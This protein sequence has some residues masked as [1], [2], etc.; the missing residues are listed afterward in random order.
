MAK[1][2]IF[3]GGVGGLT[4]AHEAIE[5]GFEVEIYDVKPALWGGKARSMGAPG[6]GVDGRFDLPGEHGFRFFPGFYKH[7]PDTMSRIPYPGNANG[8]LDNL[9]PTSQFALYR[10]DGPPFIAPVNFPD[11]LDEWK[12]AMHSIFGAHLGV[13]LDNV[14]FFAGQLLKL[15]CSCRERLDEEYDLIPWWE[16][17]EAE[18]RGVPYQKFVAQ[19][20]TRSLVAMQAKVSSTRT[21]GTM[22]LQLLYNMLTPG[23]QVDRVLN[24]PTND[25]WIRP[26]TD[27]LQAKG[28]RMQLGATLEGFRMSGS[29][30]ASAT[31]SVDGAKREIV[32]DYY[33]SAIPA[34]KM[35]TLL[36]PEMLAAD[37]KLAT[38]RQLKVEWMNGIQ[39]Y[40]GADV[41]VIRGHTIYADS[42]WALTSI[43]QHQFWNGVDLSRYGNG[44]V[45]GILSIDVSDWKTSGDKVVFKPAEE[46]TAEEIKNECWAQ[47]KAHLDEGGQ[48]QLEDSNLLG[49]HLDPD[50][51]FGRMHET[52][53]ENVEPLLI[54]VVGSL[55]LRPEAVTGIRNLFLASDYANNFTQ[56]AT[57]EGANEN[58]RRAVNGILDAAGSDA[59][60]CA[61]WPYESPAIFEVAQKADTLIWALSGGG[62]SR[63]AGA[64]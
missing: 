56:L 33:V 38:I 4:T 57:M 25:R 43:S 5:R 53:D 32:A 62:K 22:L 16:F 2:A 34:E 15:A 23:V 29:A 48:K 19:G 24:G 17:V 1:V 55:A 7:V 3:G 10:E 14:A 64:N 50:I 20:L 52:R 8:V 49:W 46:C 9:V 28:V 54:N 61:V 30:V 21:V 51:V 31:V 60:R 11:T 44:K 12:E 41:P 39:F 63:A 27:Y 45:K 40:L 36:S 26:W 13:G 37:P 47:I 35:A 18:Q 59:E 58:G 42:N 6:T